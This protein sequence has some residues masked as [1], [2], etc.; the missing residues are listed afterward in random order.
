MH[1]TEE[2]GIKWKSID[3]PVQ[4]VYTGHTTVNFIAGDAL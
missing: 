1:S 4:K 2:Y 3:L